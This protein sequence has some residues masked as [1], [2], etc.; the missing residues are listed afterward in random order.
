MQSA[1]RVSLTAPDQRLNYRRNPAGT[2][3]TTEAFAMNDRTA[4]LRTGEPDADRSGSSQ[5]PLLLRLRT[6]LGSEWG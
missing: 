6:K 5:P 4:E 3:G 2:D 1:V